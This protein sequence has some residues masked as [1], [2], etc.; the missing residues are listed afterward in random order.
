MKQ[1]VIIVGILIV[2]GTLVLLF[3]PAPSEAP[4]DTEARDQVSDQTTDDMTDTSAENTN[5]SADNSAAVDV[6]TDAGME[7]PIADTDP[8]DLSYDKLVTYTDGGFEPARLNV[9]VGETVRFF[10]E[11]SR[12][13][14][15]GSNNHPTHTLYPVK[16]GDDCLGS[17]FD[18]CEAT[19]SGAFYDF[20]FTTEGSFGY[21]NHMRA[22]DTGTIIVQ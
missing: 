5:G 19:G 17:S 16:S 2:V 10:N 3:T 1:T 7:F 13:M 14:W 6:G 18:Q 12:D 21:H 22:R 8:T 9:S 11:S 4:T 20:T 15:V